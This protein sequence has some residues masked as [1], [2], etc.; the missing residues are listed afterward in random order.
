MASVQQPATQRPDERRKYPRV[1]V[2]LDARWQTSAQASLCEVGN[3]SLGG[4]FVRTPAPPS[5]DERAF[6]T[7]Y[8][9]GRA[10]MLLA[11]RVVR[12]EP[13]V[14]FGMQF[15][16]MLPET[17]SELNQEIDKILRTHPH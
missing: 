12:V 15:R 1:P 2:T 9:K 13:G 3:L 7:L 5:P 11:G 16:E 17:K 10:S 8:L 14:G 4:C 6:I